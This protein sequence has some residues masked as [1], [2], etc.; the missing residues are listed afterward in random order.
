MF[1]SKNLELSEDSCGNEGRVLLSHK[2]LLIDILKR[3][4]NS[5]NAIQVMFFAAALFVLQGCT[6][7]P[8]NCSDEDILAAIKERFIVIGTSKSSSLGM[9]AY[10]EKLKLTGIEVVRDKQSDAQ[11]LCLAKAILNSPSGAKINVRLGFTNEELDGKNIR[12]PQMQDGFSD[13]V[14]NDMVAYVISYNKANPPPPTP[15]SAEEIRLLALNEEQLLQEVKV[16]RDFYNET[17]YALPRKIQNEINRDEMSFLANLMSYCEAESFKAKL[18][19]LPEREHEL[20]CNIKNLKSKSEKLKTLMPKLDQVEPS[21]R[22]DQNP[23]EQTANASSPNVSPQTISE[24]AQPSRIDNKPSFDCGKA[25]TTA[26]KAICSDSD[27]SRMD[28]ELATN[29]RGVLRSSLSDEEKTR[30]VST[31]RFWI[32]EREDCKDKQCISEMYQ[33][34]TQMICEAAKG[35]SYKCVQFKPTK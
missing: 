9:I 1:N 22:T 28:A 31:Q 23:T 15:K 26:E 33:M 35:Q 17:I 4:K 34:R 3:I 32:A 11:R 25:S 18:L 30:L 20:M 13:R 24:A 27:L 14:Y 21:T 19:G 16:A 2:R 29:Y 5:K 8:P 7:R 12:V 10:M 6:S